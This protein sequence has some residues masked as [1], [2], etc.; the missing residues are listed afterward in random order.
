MINSVQAHV[1][2]RNLVFDL[3]LGIFVDSLAARSEFL[4]RVN[5]GFRRLSLSS[6][7]LTWLMTLRVHL[8]LELL[9]VPS[10]SDHG[11]LLRIGHIE[12]G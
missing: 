7:R 6:F 9:E 11:S 3:H 1:A 8:E 12:Y 2:G 10:E 4:L 5:H